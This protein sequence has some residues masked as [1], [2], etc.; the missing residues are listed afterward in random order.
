MQNTQQQNQ[1][2]WLSAV[3]ESKQIQALNRACASPW[4]LAVLGLLTLISYVFALELYF[5]ALVCVYAVYICLFGEDLLTLAPL[6]LFCYIAPSAGNNP[7]KEETSVFY[8]SHGGIIILCFAALALSVL[9]FRIAT[10]E[11]MGFKKL[12]TQKRCLWRGFIVIGIAYMLSGIGSAHYFEIA[13]KNFFFSILQFLSLFLLYFL[14]SATVKWEKVDKK[15]F[16]W[17]AIVLGLTVIGQV[18][19]IYATQNVIVNN[20]IDGVV[21][22]KKINRSNIYTGWGMYNNVGAIIAIA[23]PFTLYLAITHRHGYLLV[24]LGALMVAATVFTSS[25]GSMVG[26][27]LAFGISFVYACVKSKNRVSLIITMAAFISVGTV[28]ILIFKKELTMLFSGVPD[29]FVVENLTKLDSFGSFLHLFNDSDRFSVYEEGLKVF[30]KN[31]VFGDSFYPSEFMP[32]DFSELEQLSN[33]FPPRWHN[34]IIQLLASCG[35]VGLCAYLF[36]RVETVRLFCKNPSLSKT[37]I[38]ISLGVLLVMSLLDCHM[39]NIGPVFFYSLGLLFAEKAEPKEQTQ[40]KS[41]EKTE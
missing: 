6:F 18:I 29:L 12:F 8:G 26:A 33:F 36:H 9:I 17:M 11:D 41:E 34:T 25:R 38:A 23:I 15:Y 10:D 30:V 7:G 32:W 20:V 1:I 37:F 39:F 13:G 40:E 31:P 14:F 28:M 27:I 22:G 2:S 16:A 21:V 24:C 4:G 5:Y 35:A 3:R 19:H